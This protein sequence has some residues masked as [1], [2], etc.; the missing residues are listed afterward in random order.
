[1]QKFSLLVKRE[2]VKC[3]RDDENMKNLTQKGDLAE[4]NIVQHIDD[5]KRFCIQ[6]RFKGFRKWHILARVGEGKNDFRSV[7]EIEKMA[8]SI[9]GN[10]QEDYALK[11][12]MNRMNSNVGL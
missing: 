1:M 5:D 4:L 6:G 7:Q 10:I 12:F 9:C 11:A 2:W 3:K 8:Q